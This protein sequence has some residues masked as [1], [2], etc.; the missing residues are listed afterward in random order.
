MR[1]ILICLFLIIQHSL[2]AQNLPSYLPKK[3]LVAWYPFNGSA[4]DES[5]NNLNGDSR[6]VTL[7]SDRNGANNKA[8][9]FNGVNSLI[10]IT[11]LPTTY[12]SFTYSAWINC[13]NLEL[14]NVGIVMQSGL[15][16]ATNSI[17]GSFGICVDSKNN[18]NGRFRK[19][20]CENKSSGI[21]DI[22]V[23]DTNTSKWH[24][25]TL[26]WDGN[27][28]IIY[29]DGNKSS[30]R[31]D[32]LD[33]TQVFDVLIIGAIPNGNE[34][35]WYYKGSIDDVCIWSRSLSPEEIKNLY[36]SIDTSNATGLKVNPPTQ[37]TKVKS[38]IPVKYENAGSF[39]EGLGAVK[40][41]DKWGFINKTGVIVIPFK[42]EEISSFRNGFAKVKL[43]GKYGYINR[44]GKPITQFIYDF[45]SGTFN[46]GV[47]K[48][49]K[50]NK[51]GFIDETG[52]EII[53][54]QFDDV[55]DFTYG[56]ATVVKKEFFETLNCVAYECK[57]INKQGRVIYKLDPYPQKY[58]LGYSYIGSFNKYGLAK[59]CNK[60]LYGFINNNGIEIIPIQ[61]QKI[62][63]F[64]E[65]LV[66]VYVSKYYRYTY[67]NT[68]GIQQTPEYY[69][70]AGDF[71]DGV[72]IVSQCF[73]NDQCQNP[74]FYINKNGDKV[75]KIGFICTEDD[76][77]GH[78]IDPNYS[79]LCKFGLKDFDGNKVL[80][81][82]YD[83]CPS[84]SEGIA[85]VS[86]NK[87][88]GCIDTSGKIIVP[89][90]YD[91]IFDF[92]GGVTFGTLNDKFCVINKKGIQFTPFYN[93]VKFDF[94][95]QHKVIIVEDNNKFGLI[96]LEGKT[97]IPII[98]NEIGEPSESMIAVKLNGK[99]SYLEY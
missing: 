5:G 21:L 80:P 28:L 72:A 34:A 71:I 93:K 86:L 77:G 29:L 85:S 69:T 16:C 4:N 61:Y 33:I 65:G 47:C 90:K 68:K 12:N 44:S 15:K 42:Y 53:T 98:Y 26:V 7:I 57:L 31:S 19:K 32:V 66:S 63:N 97:L 79:K 82:V 88:M 55:S 92:H 91:N 70:T 17:I 78:K 41:N 87:K 76:C 56:F 2:F 24:M 8:Y 46:E 27:N 13:N 59:V 52:V 81:M 49:S 14:K 37:V 60:K 54:T 67:F 25:L 73:G 45:L 96:D 9:Y 74:L 95:L 22:S 62:G 84:F 99:W 51:M 18:F 30:E 38:I 20:D 10:K 36:K 11:G 6:N 58:G 50:D 64:N 1:Y 75:N 40:L 39:S 23:V 83:N 48:V 43:N 89:F 35:G 94:V 3:D